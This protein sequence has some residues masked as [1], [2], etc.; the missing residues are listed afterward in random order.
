M[1]RHNVKNASELERMQKQ[2]G[3]KNPISQVTI[4]RILKA[5]AATE[6]EKQ[7]L[8]RLAEFLHETYESAFPEPGREQA[9]SIMVNGQRLIISSPDNSPVA[10]SV[11]DTIK[12]A[13]ADAEHRRK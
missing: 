10:P 2:A 4:R 1:D 3:I 5:E 11:V 13:L 6:P 7:T 9:P 12:R 8:R